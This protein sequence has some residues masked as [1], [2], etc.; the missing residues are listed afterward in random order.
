MA[1]SVAA[2][3]GPDDKSRHSVK[4]GVRG[5]DRSGS[6]AGAGAYPAVG[7]VVDLTV[8]MAVAIAGAVHLRAAAWR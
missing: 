4:T 1:R 8:T 2:P 7:H 6:T 3:A 5:I